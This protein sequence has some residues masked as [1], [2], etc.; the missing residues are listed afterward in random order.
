[1]SKFG[2]N[3]VGLRERPN[4]QRWGQCCEF[5]CSKD[6]SARSFVEEDR[7]RHSEGDHEGL[8][9]LVRDGEA[10]HVELLGQGV[11]GAIGSG[12][13]HQG[14]EGAGA[15]LEEDKEYQAQREYLPQRCHWDCQGYAP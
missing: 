4:H 1:M 8:E 9:G 3:W 6:W 5:T 13:G 11:G 7:R 10:D 14:T 15:W 2:K 12:S